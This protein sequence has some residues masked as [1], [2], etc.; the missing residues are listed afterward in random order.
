MKI[1][2]YINLLAVSEE[3][4]SGAPEKG[5]LDLDGVRDSIQKTRLFLEHIGPQFELGLKLRDDF[6]AS[7]NSKIEALKAAGYSQLLVPAENVFISEKLD[8]DQIKAI[9]IEI[10]KSLARCFGVLRTP[11][12]KPN[13]TNINDYR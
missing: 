10:D 2:D 3:K 12:D 4:I 11:T 9:Q 6:I 8:F 1:S 7:L 5:F 13:P